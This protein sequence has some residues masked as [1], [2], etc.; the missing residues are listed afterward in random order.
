MLL[1][2]LLLLEMF[3]L[4]S[5]F[6]VFVCCVSIVFFVNVHLFVIVIVNGAVLINFLV[7]LFVFGGLFCIF[8][9]IFC[10]SCYF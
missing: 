1:L 4:T 6:S 5:S 9:A 3:F 10:Y 8:C 7:S 2:L